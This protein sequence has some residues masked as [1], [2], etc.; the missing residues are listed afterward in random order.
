[1]ITH[2][3][4]RLFKEPLIKSIMPLLDLK[5]VNARRS[6]K[7]MTV[8]LGKRFNEAVAPFR[9]SPTGRSGYFALSVI[10]LRRDQS[11]LQKNALIA[12]QPDCQRYHRLDQRFLKYISCIFFAAILF[13][14]SAN[15]AIEAVQFEQPEMM[16]RYRT[17]I[18]ELRCLVCQN[19]NLADSNAALAKDLRRKTEEMLK[20]GNTDQEIYAFMRDRY[21]DFVLYRPPLNWSTAI[22]WIGPFLLLA[23]V[24]LRLLIN[25]KHKSSKPVQKN[26]GQLEQQDTARD[27]IENTPSLD[28][29]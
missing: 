10:F 22:I 12:K 2:P 15:A 24:A 26:K 28:N 19:Q 25:L 3:T 23:L 9:S 8:V 13:M 11:C 29:D 6:S 18:A 20:A 7:A 17:I 1:M 14:N 5:G 4:L 27:L 16:Q 21:G